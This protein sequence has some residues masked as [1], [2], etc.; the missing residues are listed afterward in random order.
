MKKDHFTDLLKWR[1]SV[2]SIGQLLTNYI[3]VLDYRWFWGLS[4]TFPLN[5]KFYMG[6]VEH[7]ALMALG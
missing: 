3:S 4:S 1:Y 5:Y 6:S 7:L 2:R